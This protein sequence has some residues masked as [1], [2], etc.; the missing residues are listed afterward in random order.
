[1]DRKDIEVLY[2]VE[3]LPPWH[4]A[5][6]LGLQHVLVM[7]ASNVTIPIIIAGVVGATTG[8]PAFLVQVALLVAGLTT[9][10]QTIGIGPVGARLPVVQRTRVGGRRV[11]TPHRSA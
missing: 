2:D 5:I 4:E 10:L 3:E 6:P 7:V 11:A 8:E 1:M 9:L